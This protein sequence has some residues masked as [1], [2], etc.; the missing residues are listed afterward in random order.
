M[1]ALH[2][3]VR[4]QALLQI[5]NPRDLTKSA[6]CFLQCSKKLACRGIFFYSSF[7]ALALLQVGVRVLNHS[8]LL[9]AAVI[10][11]VFAHETVSPM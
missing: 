3:N 9:L 11:S 1:N 7:V 4:V 2:L 8:I 10:A 6:F 5:S